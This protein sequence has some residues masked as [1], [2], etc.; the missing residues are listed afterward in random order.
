MSKIKV[1]INGFGRI[2]RLVFR[3]AMKR[4]DIEIVGI[5]DLIDVNYMAY[6]LRYDSMHGRFDG[7]IEIKDGR[8]VVNG[9]AIRVTAERNPEDIDDSEGVEIAKRL[10]APEGVRPLRLQGIPEN[11]CY[12]VRNGEVAIVL[13]DFSGSPH[14][15]VVF[16]M[17]HAILDP[18]RLLAERDD[19]GDCASWPGS[20]QR[21][22]VTGAIHDS[23]S[24]RWIWLHHQGPMNLRIP[25]EN[26]VLIEHSLQRSKN[27]KAPETS[28]SKE[29]GRARKRL[30]ASPPYSL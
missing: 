26:A 27:T 9:H 23:T 16:R 4:D 5:N 2:G 24:L 3:A 17:P 8:L 15:K 7:T 1:G 28:V 22:R 29:H 11:P 19:Q 25:R 6:M 30:E 21:E 12:K 10:N 20:F 13:L 14:D 18:E